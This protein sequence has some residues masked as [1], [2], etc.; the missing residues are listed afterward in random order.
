MTIPAPDMAADWKDWAKQLKQNL[1]V[2]APIRPLQLPVYALVQLPKA[3]PAGQLICISDDFEPYALAI[4]DGTDWRRVMDG[5][6][7]G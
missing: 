4:S 2:A 6:V 3:T 5:E 1:D 7:V